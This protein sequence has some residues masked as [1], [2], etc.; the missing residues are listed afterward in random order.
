VVDEFTVAL[1]VGSHDELRPEDLLW[2]YPGIHYRDLNATE[3]SVLILDLQ[4]L[5]PWQAAS[6]LE[7]A[8]DSD[9]TSTAIG[10][11]EVQRVE[12]ARPD[13]TGFDIAFLI[14]PPNL[15]DEAALQFVYNQLAAVYSPFTRVGIDF[16]PTLV[17]ANLIPANQQAR[18][19]GQLLAAMFGE[20]APAVEPVVSEMDPAYDEKPSPFTVRERTQLLEL[21][22][23]PE[24]EVRLDN[25]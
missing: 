21:A 12:A 14:R 20:Y 16:L 24:T 23:R 3:E 10:F 13:L 7:T 1:P 15:P 2:I 25:Q 9:S 8:R 4:T 22:N 11:G 18:P 6:F 19:G 17:A 5:E